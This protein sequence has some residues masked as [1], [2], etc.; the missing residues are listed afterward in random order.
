MSLVV[1]DQIFHTLQ[2][3]V[4]TRE[5]KWGIRDRRRQNSV[6]ELRRTKMEEGT[7]PGRRW[8]VRLDESVPACLLQEMADAYKL[9]R[10]SS[11]SL[12]P[13]PKRPHTQQITKLAH[14]AITHTKACLK[15]STHMPPAWLGVPPI[16][17]VS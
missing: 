2:L 4:K 14:Y 15:S 5:W 11:N 16:F 1:Y 12:G 9:S 3:C 17:S 7:S 8:R 10:Q 6:R 13:T